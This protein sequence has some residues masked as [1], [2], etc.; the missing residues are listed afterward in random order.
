[1][2]GKEEV[3]NTDSYKSKTK[4]MIRTTC[5]TMLKVI[6]CE[7][8]NT[9]KSIEINGEENFT[10]C[11]KGHPELPSPSLGLIRFCE[12]PKPRF[13]KEGSKIFIS[14]SILIDERPHWVKGE[15]KESLDPIIITNKDVVMAKSMMIHNPILVNEWAGICGIKIQKPISAMIDEELLTDLELIRTDPEL[16]ISEK[17]GAKASP[18]AEETPVLEGL[19]IHFSEIDL[20]MELD[21]VRDML[22]SS[23]KKIELTLQIEALPHG[24]GFVT[25]DDNHEEKKQLQGRNI[26]AEIIMIIERKPIKERELL[27]G[28]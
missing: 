2:I 6:K 1:M 24:K 12:D 20:K 25:I 16:R 22:S 11:Q 23:D 5:K 10:D 21:E 28:F 15:I 8:N 17:F 9:E 18:N 4:G 7:E 19:E 27:M 3:P 14:G 13:V 26:Q